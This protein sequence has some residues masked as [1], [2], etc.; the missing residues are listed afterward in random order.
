MTIEKKYKWALTGFV[1]MLVLNL[2]TLTTIWIGGTDT[3]DWDRQ[4]DGERGRTAV[5][6]FMQKELGLSESQVES[7]AEMRKSHFREVRELRSK[8]EAQ[9][10]AYFEFIMGPDSGNLQKRDSILTELKERFAEI[11]NAFY[12]HMTEMKTVLNAEQQQK[13][14]QLMKESMLHDHRGNGRR[15]QRNR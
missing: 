7:I 10:H 3:P 11:D 5:H 8:L 4:A 15:M 1:V 13:F 12:V 2:A 6:K 14:K 9:R